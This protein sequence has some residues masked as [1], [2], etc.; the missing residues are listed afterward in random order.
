MKYHLTSALSAPF[1]ARQEQSP[2]E[3]PA[4]ASPSASAGAPKEKPDRMRPGKAAGT[5]PRPKYVVNTVDA[6]NPHHTHRPMKRVVGAV[7]G[8]LA[9]VLIAAWFFLIQFSHGR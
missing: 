3:V 1:A 7:L 9:I 6:P 5:R 4:S 2:P 8:I